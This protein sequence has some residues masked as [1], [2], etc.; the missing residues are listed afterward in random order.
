M[1]DINSY[2]FVERMGESVVAREYTPVLDG[3]FD[4][5]LSQVVRGIDTGVVDNQE[6]GDIEKELGS[7][8]R[9]S[10]ASNVSNQTAVKID[11]GEQTGRDGAGAA[12]TDG[13]SLS[14][15]AVS[16]DSFGP[17][18]LTE[19]TPDPIRRGDSHEEHSETGCSMP[20][21]ATNALD[22]LCS[23]DSCDTDKVVDSLL[24]TGPFLLNNGGGLELRDLTAD[25]GCDDIG[26]QDREETPIPPREEEANGRDGMGLPTITMALISR[27]SR[28][29]AGEGRNYLCASAAGWPVGSTMLTCKLLHTLSSST[30]LTGFSLDGSSKLL[31]W[32][33]LVYVRVEGVVNSTFVYRNPLPEEGSG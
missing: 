8:T 12:V 20:S 9:F 29:R 22:F 26:K 32:H 15:S 33:S 7:D 13:R 1:V 14:S 19:K 11:Y 2:T 5:Q 16:F 30:N 18:V 25:G 4:N 17:Q 10:I 23:T 21:S 27:R 6:S 28:H 24:S 31:L 3:Y